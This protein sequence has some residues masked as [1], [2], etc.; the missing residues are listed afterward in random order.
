[1]TD[2]QQCPVKF[3]HHHFTHTFNKW[4]GGVALHQQYGQSGNETTVHW[5]AMFNGR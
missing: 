4:S 5:Q 1:M 2:K 3:F